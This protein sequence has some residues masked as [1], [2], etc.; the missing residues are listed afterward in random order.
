MVA[1]I[2]IRDH[3]LRTT[4]TH[5]NKNSY[6]ITDQVVGISHAYLCPDK[7][8]IWLEGIRINP[9]FR[10]MGIASMLIIRLIEYGIRAQRNIREVA[11]ITTETNNTA[12]HMLEKNA[13]EKRALW[14]CYAASKEKGLMTIMDRLRT[15]KYISKRNSVHKNQHMYVTLAS[16]NDIEEIITFP[17]TSKSFIAGGRRYVQSWR[18]YGLDLKTSKISELV[19][20]KQI[21]IV[22]HGGCRAIGALTITSRQFHTGDNML[23]L[24]LEYLDARNAVFLESLLTFIMDYVVLSNKIDRIQVFVPNQADKDNS[25]FHVNDVLAR[26][27]IPRFERFLLYTRKICSC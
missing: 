16:K 10:R 27:G 23:S 9:L 13:F 17:S 14:T 21:I 25:Y 15:R 11:A 2:R 1:E 6:F 12:R 3:D 18:W 8:Q 4:A 24:H 5:R 7:K 26:Y 22:R 19:T 20:N